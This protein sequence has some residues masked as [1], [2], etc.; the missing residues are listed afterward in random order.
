MSIASAVID[1]VGFL[2][3]AVVDVFALV[4]AALSAGLVPLTRLWAVC[5]GR[6]VAVLMQPAGL[7]VTV[8]AVV[9]GTWVGGARTMNDLVV[10]GPPEPASGT[11]ATAP[12]HSRIVVP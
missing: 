11:P 1:G 5:S 4:E 8:I 10:D 12:D 3:R 7:A 2:P 6:S 9:I